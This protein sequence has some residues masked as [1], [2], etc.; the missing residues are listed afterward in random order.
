MNQRY[1][2]L[3]AML[4]CILPTTTQAVDLTTIDRSSKKAELSI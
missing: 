1:T 2:L 3:A 4:F